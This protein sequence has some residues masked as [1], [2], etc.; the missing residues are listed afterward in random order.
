[1]DKYTLMRAVCSEVQKEGSVM[2]V[3]TY[4]IRICI[5]TFN[6]YTHMSDGSTESLLPQTDEIGLQIIT[7]TPISNMFSRESPCI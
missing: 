7:T 1:M 5:Y 3:F 4:C 2:Y 6:V